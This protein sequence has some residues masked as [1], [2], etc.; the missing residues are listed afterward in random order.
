MSIQPT[1]RRVAKPHAHNIHSLSTNKQSQIFQLPDGRALGYAEYGTPSGKPL[2]Y[3]HGYPSSRIEAEAID[4]MA[5][6][7]G[8]RL[9]ALDRPGFGLSTLQLGRKMLDWPEDVRAFAAGVGLD[10]FAIMGLSGGGPFALA[11]AYALPK[12]MVSAVGLFASGPAWEAGAHHMSLMRRIM[13]SMSKYWPTGL[14]VVLSLFV[15]T[16]RAIATSNPV[17]KRVDAWLATE[18]KKKEE[19]QKSEDAETSEQ[20][21]EQQPKKTTKERREYL[22]RMLI[23]EPFGQGSAPTVQEADL[24]SSQNWGFKLEDVDFDPVRIWHGAKDGNAPIVMMRYMAN[25]LPH[26]ILH[27]YEDDSH[28]TMFPHIEGAMKELSEDYDA[29]TPKASASSSL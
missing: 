15:R 1:L 11:C 24:L 18:S 8:L 22:L 21:Q 14:G 25:K 19:K 2:L 4:D 6:R 23:D 17:T 29:R 26:S 3:F 5:R 13:S 27:E 7:C 16:L 9:L 20:E 10:R 12:N 28:Y